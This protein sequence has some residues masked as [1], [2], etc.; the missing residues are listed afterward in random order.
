MRGRSRLEEGRLS[1]YRFVPAV[2]VGRRRQHT[3]RFILAT[4]G[5][6]TTVMTVTTTTTTVT[7]PILKL[8]TRG[9]LQWA[10][11]RARVAV[12]YGFCVVDRAFTAHIY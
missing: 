7:M 4:F 10:R 12:A 11:A 9:F 8:H 1:I 2:A 3:S 6:T 5:P